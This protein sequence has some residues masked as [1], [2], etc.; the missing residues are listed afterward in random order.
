VHPF[1]S[2][3]APFTCEQN[4]LALGTPHTGHENAHLLSRLLL[5]SKIGGFCSFDYILFCSFDCIVCEVL[6]PDPNSPA[7]ISSTVSFR[8]QV[9]TNIIGSVA[10]RCITAA[11]QKKI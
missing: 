10:K 6:C 3:P 2:D 4:R 9:V 1:W 7:L 8:L 11:S 5:S